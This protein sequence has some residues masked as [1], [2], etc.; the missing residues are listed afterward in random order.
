MRDVLVISSSQSRV[1]KEV[2]LH[3]GHDSKFL[4]LP[5]VRGIRR[6]E[7]TGVY[8]WREKSSVSKLKMFSFIARNRAI[9]LERRS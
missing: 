1:G 3:E 5:F 6:D 9:L 4:G 8:T 7:D 2:A